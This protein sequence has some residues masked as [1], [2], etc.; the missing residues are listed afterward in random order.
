MLARIDL[1]PDTFGAFKKFSNA[2]EDETRPVCLGFHQGQYNM[3]LKMN[4][5]SILHC[6]KKIFDAVSFMFGILIHH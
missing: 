6:K 4:L 3:S 5:S 1:I 2:D